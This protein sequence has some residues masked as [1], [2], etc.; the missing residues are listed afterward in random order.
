MMSYRDFVELLRMSQELREALELEE[1]PH[2]STAF[3]KPPG[4]DEPAV[5]AALRGGGGGG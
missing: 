4:C 3:V 5:I 2:Y 1:A